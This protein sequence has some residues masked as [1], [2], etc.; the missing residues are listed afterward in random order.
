MIHGNRLIAAFV[1]CA[2]FALAACS[3]KKETKPDTAAATEQKDSLTITL[4]GQ[5]SVS[6][7]TLLTKTHQVDFV[8]SAMGVFVKG[9][10][11]IDNDTDYFWM[12]SVNDTLAPV[13]ADQL[14]TRTGDRVVWHFRQLT[15]SGN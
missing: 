4:T 13:A 1:F 10:D 12:Y 9:I 2:V 7:F 14:V 15:G 8:S 5:D 3:A 11:S 6:V